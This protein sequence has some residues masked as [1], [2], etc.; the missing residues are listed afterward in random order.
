MKWLAGGEDYIRLSLGSEGDT[1]VDPN[2][3][4]F[5]IPVSYREPK[6]KQ[7]LNESEPFE[8][9]TEMELE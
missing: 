7:E 2:A 5:T 1:E 3:I 8:E 6:S 4:H 9:P